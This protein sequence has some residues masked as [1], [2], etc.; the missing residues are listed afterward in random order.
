MA[1]KEP[2]KWSDLSLVRKIFMIV[3]S[4]S[5]SVLFMNMC[6]GPS[7]QSLQEEGPILQVQNS[8]FDNSV[9]QVKKYLKT[10]LNDADSYESIGW[11]QVMKQGD[12]FAVYHEYRA[13]NAFGA[14]I[15][16]SQMFYLD[17]LGN[18]FN[19]EDKNPQ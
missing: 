11:G 2:V 7:D 4:L 6:M 13:K 15:K 1:K 18:V 9:P 10:V 16:A 12:N 3:G 8:P 17:S 5:F 14:Y 19:V